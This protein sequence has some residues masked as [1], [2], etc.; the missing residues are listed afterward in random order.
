MKI[1]ESEFF[2]E[3]TLRICGSLDLEKA[4]WHCLLYV[5]EI[6][7]ADEL[8]LTVYDL[9]LGVLETV[10]S[11]TEKG[12]KT[13]SDKVPMPAPLRRELEEVLRYPRVRRSNDV[14]DDPIVGRLAVSLDWPDSSVII[15]RLIIEGQFVGSLIIRADG[16]G[17][18]TEKHEKLWS[19]VNE[20]AAI[21]LANSRQYLELLRLKELLD[22]DNRYFQNELRRNLS[23]EIVGAHSGLK[24]VMDQVMKVA[25]LTSPVLLMGETGTG[26]EV[27]ANAIHNL[28]PRSSGPLITVNCGAIP[29]TLL[30]SELFGH[31]KGAFTGALAQK[32]GRFE[33]AN[34]GTIFLDEVA[35]LPLPAQV[36]FLRVIQEKEIERIGGIGSVRVDIRVISATHRDLAKRVEEGLFREDL[37]YRLGVFPIYIPP[38][39]ERKEDIPGLMEHFI[40][41]KSK[42][43]GLVSLSK[44]ASGA[45]DRLM[46]Y[47]WPGNVRELGNVV[48]RA[49]IQSGGKTLTFDDVSSHTTK[50]FSTTAP[51][52]GDSLALKGI[53]AQ[54]IRHVME[55]TGGRV[56]GENGAAKLLGMNPGTLRHKMRKLGILFGKRKN[57]NDLR[58]KGSA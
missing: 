26:K 54:H 30:D 32:R 46:D 34:R 2:K 5:K 29:E 8:I 48:E 53:E 45:I 4:L 35:E 56:E 38:L 50:N 52:G 3:V 25:P 58:Q 36:R 19:L 23:N 14:F 16:K 33:R 10:A 44:L 18:Y 24:N 13:R 28:S 20:P 1:N 22:D 31:E 42:E 57:G 43:M 9:G 39:R 27:I 6:I 7:P 40:R 37:F 49:L 51:S 21:A 55:I 41:E 11:A 12:G 15:A 17:R 47:D